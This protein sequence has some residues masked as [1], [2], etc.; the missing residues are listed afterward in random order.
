V[1]GK[2]I[3]RRSICLICALTHRRKEHEE[4]KILTQPALQA[5]NEQ[6]KKKKVKKKPYIP[7]LIT[8]TK[9]HPLPSRVAHDCEPL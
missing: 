1:V 3:E 6:S 5:V 4:F 2:Q 8:T 9:T 7:V